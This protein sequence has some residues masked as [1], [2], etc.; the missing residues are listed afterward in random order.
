MKNYSSSRILNIHGWMTGKLYE[1]KLR[2]T[3]NFCMTVCCLNTH[4]N[5]TNMQNNI[6]GKR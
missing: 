2:K 4:F 6:N 3:D 1:Q 5:Y